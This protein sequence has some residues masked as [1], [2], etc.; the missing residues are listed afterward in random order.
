MKETI[1]KTKRQPEWE[2]FPNDMS[3][4]G[5]ISKIYK[6]LTQHYSKRT[7]KKQR[8]YDLKMGRGLE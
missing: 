5:L 4:K 7:K 6:E 8:K 3:N 2:I 1:N